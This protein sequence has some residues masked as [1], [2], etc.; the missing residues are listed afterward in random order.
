MEVGGGVGGGQCSCLS[1][2][3]KGGGCKWNE[4]TK[5]LG[6]LMTFKTEGIFFKCECVV[7]VL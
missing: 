7:C 4:T 3:K 5:H 6:G 1:K 2:K